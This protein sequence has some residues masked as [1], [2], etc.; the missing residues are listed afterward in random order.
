MSAIDNT[1]IK[2]EVLLWDDAGFFDKLVNPIKNYVLLIKY[3]NEEYVAIKDGYAKFIPKSKVKDSKIIHH[4]V[5]QVKF[6]DFNLGNM[7][8]NKIVRNKK[9]ITSQKEFLRSYAYL[10]GSNVPYYQKKMD[11]DKGFYFTGWC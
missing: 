9:R 6:K 3:C 2:M 11:Y 7:L 8:L 5:K 10:V 4:E 1:T